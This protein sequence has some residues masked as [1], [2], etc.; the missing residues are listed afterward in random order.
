MNLSFFLRLFFIFVFG[1]VISYHDLKDRKI[2][3][4]YIL[5]MGALGCLLFLYKADPGLYMDYTINFGLCFLIGI[6]FWKG[7]LWNPGDG[8]LFTVCSL[9]LPASF[10]NSWFPSQTLLLNFFIL[11][12]LIWM[13]SMAKNTEFG[14]FIGVLKENAKPKKILNLVLLI[15]GFFWA[16]ESI[17]AFFGMDKFILI[18]LL[19]LVSLY[20]LKNHL[21][22][23]K[24]FVFLI[25]LVALRLSFQPLNSFPGIIEIMASL[26][27]LLFF[28]SLGNL[29]FK[30]SYKG[31]HLNQVSPGD[32]PSGLVKDNNGE[33]SNEEL[34]KVLGQRF[35]DPDRIISKGF[36]ESDIKNLEELD[37]QG[38]LIKKYVP[39]APL[40]F[41]ATIITIFLGPEVDLI[42]SA[43]IDVSGFFL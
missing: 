5:T 24:L 31:K 25:S 9:Y 26:A 28:I 14:D 39:F 12:F 8:K 35:E 38:F 43:I 11:A 1:V 40:F 2:H 41:V 33:R 36:K 13:P 30:I 3:N 7:G 10:Y 16:L 19:A 6:G 37:I 21:E 20:F 15:L 18:F 32:I 42:A 4:K 29:G 27:V 22:E 23:D 17:L 34:K